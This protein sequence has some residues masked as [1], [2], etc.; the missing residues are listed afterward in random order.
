MTT[1]GT[2]TPIPTFAPPDRPLLDGM[3]VGAVFEVEEEMGAVLR[4][5]RKCARG[6]SLKR[7]WVPEMWCY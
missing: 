5:K 2:A 3:D 1:K 6:L 7:K 4:L